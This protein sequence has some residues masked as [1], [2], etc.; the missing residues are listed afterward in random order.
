MTNCDNCIWYIYQLP[1]EPQIT[2]VTIKSVV[3]EMRT[4]CLGVC[5]YEGGTEN[6]QRRSNQ[7][8]EEQNGRQ[9]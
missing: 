1:T 7:N 6:D 8:S 3:P 4:C 5:R 2:T 9:C